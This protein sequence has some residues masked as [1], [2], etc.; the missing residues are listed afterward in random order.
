MDTDILQIGRLTILSVLDTTTVG[1]PSAMW[2]GRATEESLRPH[3][4]WL[5]ERGLMHFR[6]G[7]FVI[8]D[9]NGPL[10]LVDTGYGGRQREPKPGG[11]RFKTGNLLDGLSRDGIQPEDVD[12]VLLTHLHVDHVGW[13]T[14]D[15]DGRPVTTFPK[16][17]YLVQQQEWDYWS[18]PDRAGSEEHVQDCML[19][20][21]KAGQLD[22]L[23]GE[24]TISQ[25]ITTVSTPGH[26]PG[27]ISVVLISDGER[28]VITGD[29]AHSPIQLTETEWSLALDLDP[30]LA[31]RTRAAFAERFDSEGM[32]VIG[33]HFP[34]PGFG[35][36]IQ[37]EGRRYWR[38]FEA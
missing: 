38:P 23:D 10:V 31:A 28:G 17:R 21:Q 14:I 36:L 18:H 20:L 22:L 11:L 7:S 12:I 13:N 6:V 33:T 9:G 34:Q 19:P 30:G 5:D 8:R 37:L 3:E 2:P 35:R 25:G 4:L 26:T 32:A 1:R 16:A 15:L 24:Q 29:I 27:H